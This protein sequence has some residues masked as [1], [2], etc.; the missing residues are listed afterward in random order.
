MKFELSIVIPTYNEE[1]RIGDTLD[2]LSKYLNKEKIN[3]EV[4]VVDAGSPDKTVDVVKKHS[5]TFDR[6]RII[7]AGPKPKGKFIKGK[8]VKKGMLEAKGDNVLFMDADL[9]TPLKYI[10]Q[11]LI[12]LKSGNQVSICIRN[13]QKSHK[14]LRKFISGAGNFLV[15]T[16]LLP[17]ISDTQCGF[18]AFTHEAAQAVF[19][20]QTIDSWGFDMEILAIARK[21]GYSIGLINVPD[22]EDVMEGSKI[23]GSSPIKASVQTLGDLSKIKWQSL[24]GK[25]KG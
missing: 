24:S 13:L 7:N 11:A 19:P 1:G 12:Q 10:K 4:L 22:W 3:A 14:G 2:K 25:Y 9:A 16:V 21:K 8:Q 17:G 18:K 15:Q 6:L 20:L 23:T 5:K